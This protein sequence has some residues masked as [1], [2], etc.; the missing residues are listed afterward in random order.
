[1]FKKVLIV[2]FCVVLYIVTAVPI[3]MFLFTMKMDMGVDIFKRT[4]FHGYVACLKS[5]G[6]K[7]LSDDS[8]AD[9]R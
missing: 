8:R 6:K 9:Y 3:G 1:M 7:A 2:L 5:E 4:G